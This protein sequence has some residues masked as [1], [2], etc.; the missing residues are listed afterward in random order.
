MRGRDKRKDPAAGAEAGT[1]APVPAVTVCR[2]S[3]GKKGTRCS[4]Y[5]GEKVYL[6]VRVRMPV[7]DLLRNSRLS[8][9]QGPP[10][11]GKGHK[12]SPGNRK[13]ARTC[14]RERAARAQRP[15]KSLEELAIIIEV[16]EEDLRSG[17][18]YHP[19]LQS[20]AACGFPT[21]PEMSPTEAACRDES[22]EMIPSPE[23][24]MIYSPGPAE[25]HHAMSPPDCMF[26][27][28]QLSGGENVHRS[29]EQGE[30]W[31]HPHDCD[32]KLSSSAF[33]WAQLQREE[34]KLRGTSDADLLASNEHGRTV[35]HTVVCLGKRAL[36]FAIAE[37]MAALSSLDLKDADGMT[38]LLYAAKHNH[39][40]MVA[41]LIR[42]G[43]NVNETNN[44]GKSCLHLSAENGYVRVL[45]VLK[46]A[47]MDG[48]FIDM[49]A[50]DNSGMSVL[51]SA[52]LALK[53]SVSKAESKLHTLRQEQMMETLGCLLQMESYHHT[54][55]Q[56]VGGEPAHPAHPARLPGR[57]VWKPNGNV[58]S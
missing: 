28:F 44:S 48:V 14:H 20:L 10:D 32:Q 22:D 45:E 19:P 43:A 51:Q 25:Y 31:F 42:L 23:S 12:P 4:I 7:R 47:M 56:S 38:A 2:A 41:D 1:G 11:Q 40:L 29:G 46:Q 17:N 27:P 53:T 9:G 15:M 37:R 8:Q 26:S 30:E 55:C 13:R 39:H 54:V 35:L 21:H 36:G 5:G 52:S 57:A 58:L 34:S 33:F 3:G 6:G 24:Y 49:E 18:T 16:L 50:T